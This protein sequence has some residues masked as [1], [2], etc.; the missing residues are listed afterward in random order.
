[1]DQI[2][3]SS[4]TTV[5]DIKRMSNKFHYNTVQC[6]GRNKIS[7]GLGMRDSIGTFGKEF[8]LLALDTHHAKGAKSFP[9][10]PM[11]LFIRAYSWLNTNICHYNTAIY[12]GRNKMSH[13]LDMRNSIGTFGKDFALFELFEQ[14]PSLVCQCCLSSGP[15]HE[16]F[17]MLL[18]V[19]L[20]LMSTFR[21]L[22][23]FCCLLFP[24]YLIIALSAENQLHD[25]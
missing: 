3:A 23:S 14:N 7:H 11:L 17:Y 21:V 13:G 1:M 16:R 9:W 20:L 5:R 24:C 6:D 12:D 2:R 8:A 18:P 19:D 25:I 22:M 10:G 15:T 4:T